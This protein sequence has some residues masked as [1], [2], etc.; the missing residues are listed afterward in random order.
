MSTPAYEAAATF[1]PKRLAALD[2]RYRRSVR[3][4]S[5]LQMGLGLLLFL[6]AMTILGAVRARIPGWPT[7]LACGF[8]AV[9]LIGY[10]KTIAVRD[11]LLRLMLHYERAAERLAGTAV[12]TGSGGEEFR[13]EGHLYERD[14]NVLGP[15]SLFGR[16]DTVRTGVGQ[17]GLAK[18]LLGGDRVTA[19]DEILA[20]REAIRELTPTNN[21]R[22]TLALLG[23]SRFQQVPATFFDGWLTEAPPEFPRW[24]RFSLFGTTGLIV[25]LTIFGMFH[26]MSWETVRPNLLGVF[27]VQGAIAM[28]VRRRVVVLL[29][30][31]SRL[32]NQVEIFREGLACLR[33]TEFTANRLRAL[34]QISATPNDATKLLRRLQQQLVIVEQRT[35]E[36]FLVPSL[37]FCL[38]THAAISIARWK[39]EYASAMTLWLEAWA[40]FEALTALGTYAYEHPEYTYP[41]ML[42]TGTAVFEAK[43]MAHPLLPAEAVAND[44]CLNEKTRMY[45]ISGSNMAGKSTLLRSI[46]MNA[47]LANTGAPIRARSARISPFLP[48]ASIALTDSLAEGRSKFLAEVERLH[49]M[50][51]AAQSS[52]RRCVLFLVDEIFSGTNSLDRK[53]AAEAVARALIKHGGIG[54]LSTHDLTLTEMA[55]SRELHAINVHMG[56]PDAADPL[57]F[58]YLLK[59]GVNASSNALA[60]LRMMGIEIDR[61]E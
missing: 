45:L 22:E 26:L 51:E 19:D 12:Q 53:I 31:S 11:R 25:L 40:E 54:A 48:G 42:P 14:L 60:I 50:L 32:S 15:D 23:V 49:A 28:A 41:E 4:V 47:V 9:A 56:S 24:L 58:D 46:G 21:L 61:A 5:R 2:E 59:P 30:S 3:R 44:L 36:W 27:A 20:R 6:I 39:R 35:K 10:F 7:I 29:D 33:R 52:D 43:A 57:R 34:Q 18:L 55:E 37:L 38:G 8:F 13:S 1:Y 16:L 17:R